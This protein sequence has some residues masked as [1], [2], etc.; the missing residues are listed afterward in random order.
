MNHLLCG[1]AG[2][3]LCRSDYFDLLEQKRIII[4][5]SGR[6]FTFPTV[7]IYS[8]LYFN[9]LGSELFIFVF[10]FLKFIALYQVEIFCQKIVLVILISVF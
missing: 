6:L 3:L 9:G 5:S 4:D 7:F 10:L 2:L 1:P 8:F